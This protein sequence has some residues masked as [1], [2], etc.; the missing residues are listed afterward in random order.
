MSDPNRHHYIPQFYLRRW[1]NDR[2]LVSSYSW[3]GGKIYVGD[4]S[5]RSIGAEAGLYALDGV[6]PDMR[7]AIERDVM[8]PMIDGPAADA[9]AVLLGEVSGPLSHEARLAWIR[10][11]V[12]LMVRT[13][14]QL[15]ALKADGAATLRDQLAADPEE[16]ER[17]RGPNDPPTFLEFIKARKLD[18]LI[19]N[20][21]T[22]MMPQL[23]EIPHM[24]RDIFRMDWRVQHYRD[25]PYGFVTSDFPIC[26]LPG[27]AY[28]DCIISLPLSPTAVF[29]AAYDAKLIDAIT[30]QPP[31]RVIDRVNEISVGSARRYV[32]ADSRQYMDLVGQ[33]LRQ[34]DC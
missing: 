22:A 10:F 1:A 17:V 7:N 19:D 27:L 15:A 18:H 34:P 28:R 26:M 23:T 20:F 33:G 14:A 9:M 31:D 5:P 13:P 11:L 4:Y 16:Y 21:G 29:L 25:G 24:N 12:S 30:A 2:G 3:Q 8:G 6:P 32:F